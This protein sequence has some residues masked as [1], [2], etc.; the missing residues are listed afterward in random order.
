[1]RPFSCLHLVL[2]LK[3]SD[4]PPPTPH[5]P[6]RNKGQTGALSLSIHETKKLDKLSTHRR[7]RCT[8]EATQAPRQF[9]AGHME[10]HSPKRFL[11]PQEIS[12]SNSYRRMPFAVS[13]VA[14]D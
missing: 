8:R 6:S 1:M 4:R 3:N 2:R 14:P 10:R 11:K 7:K 9:G 13:L 5:T 12:H